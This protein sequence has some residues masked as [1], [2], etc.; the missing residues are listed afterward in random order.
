MI[1]PFH[2]AYHVNDLTQ[3]CAFYSGLLGCTEGRS[4]ATWVDFDFFGHQMQP[5]SGRSICPCQYWESW[6]SSCG[7]TAFWACFAV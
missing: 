5:A 1:S 2:L 3:A 7:D 4:T 6:R